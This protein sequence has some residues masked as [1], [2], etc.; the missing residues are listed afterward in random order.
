MAL[1]ILLQEAI[2][3]PPM[4]THQV[5]EISFLIWKKC[6]LQMWAALFPRTRYRG[7]VYEGIKIRDAFM[8]KR[9]S[10][11]KRRSVSSANAV[12]AVAII[13]R[14][15]DVGVV[16]P[17]EFYHVIFGL[18]LLRDEVPEPLVLHL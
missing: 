12:F 18:I 1:Y 13:P 17:P 7:V 15:G 5:R 2:Y 11:I 9:T 4:E 16:F 14:G 10:V 3:T 6:A 8:S